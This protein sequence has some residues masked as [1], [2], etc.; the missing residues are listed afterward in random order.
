MPK[1]N[2]TPNKLTYIVPTIG[3][4]FLFAILTFALAPSF[5]LSTSALSVYSQDSTSNTPTLTSSSLSMTIFPATSPNND[6]SSA[7]TSRTLDSFNVNNLDSGTHSIRN[8]TNYRSHNVSIKASNIEYYTLSISYADGSNALVNTK[9]IGIGNSITMNS[10]DNNGIKGSNLSDNTWGWGWSE[11]S[12]TNSSDLLYKPVLTTNSTIASNMNPTNNNIDVNG[13]LTFA[14]KFSSDAIGG[15][16]TTNVKLTLV[17]PAVEVVKVFDGITTMQAMTSD[18]CGNAKENDTAQ[19]IDTRDNKTYWVTKLKDGNCWMTQ[20]LGLDLSNITLTSAD[21]NV[22]SS[23]TPNLTSQVWYADDTVVAYYDPGEYVYTT[24]TVRNGCSNVE[25]LSDC[26]VKG[27]KDVSGLRKSADANFY[28]DNSD[29]VHNA[30][31]YD[32]HFLV[33]NF[34]SFTAAIAGSSI[35]SNFVPTKDICPKGWR[36]PSHANSALDKS[37]YGLMSSY[38][39]TPSSS[40]DINNLSL[41]VRL[42]PLFLLYGGRLDGRN[43][44][45]AAARATQG[46]LAGMGSTGSYWVADAGDSAGQGKYAFSFALGSAVTTSSGTRS[47]GYSVRCVAE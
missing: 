45:G 25:A 43:G 18:I 34:Y 24:P 7:N 2:K 11:S 38:G 44:G 26:V 28:K 37:Y 20:N 3:L 31:E 8:T 35:A 15:N 1:A 13:T 32:A 22:T 23:W 6:I 42:S 29:S 36:L 4:F 10:V 14:A 39:I 17:A 5:S 40:T 46:Y 21:S 47:Y 27:W 41:D 16:Y 9:P 33:G 19:L 12:N 30:T